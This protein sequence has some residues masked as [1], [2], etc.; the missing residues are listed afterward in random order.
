[1]IN[2]AIEII[3]LLIGAI[4]LA[5]VIWLVLYGINTFVTPIPDRLQQGIWFIVLLLIII[6]ALTL[7]AGGSLRSWSIHGS[8]PHPHP[9]YAALDL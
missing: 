3:W 6:G 9:T 8:G 7:L 1:M 2:I 5:G 4:C